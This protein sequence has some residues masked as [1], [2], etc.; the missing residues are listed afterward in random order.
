MNFRMKGKGMADNYQI[1]AA[2]NA[3]RLQIHLTVW[4]SKY[5]EPF[6]KIYSAGM[7]KNLLCLKLPL[8][9]EIP[10]Y[11]YGRVLALLESKQFNGAWYD[12]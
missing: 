1:H 12:I 4:L 11:I 6:V 9:P 10:N 2:L 8:P 7:C 3:K 5:L